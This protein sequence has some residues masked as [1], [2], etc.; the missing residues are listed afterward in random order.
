MSKKKLL[1]QGQKTGNLI[2]SRLFLGISLVI[3]G[4]ILVFGRSGGRSLENS[5]AN[6]PVKVEGFNEVK[7]QED[8]EP[9]RV[10]IP[11]AGIDLPV[12]RAEIIRGYWEVFP[13]TAAWGAGS[14]Y[15]GEAGNQ[16]VF[17]HAREGLFLPLKDVRIDDKVYI[18]T[19]DG[20]FDYKITEIKDV[21][22][23]QIEV[24]APTDDETLTLYTC[25]G[26]QDSKRLIVTAKRV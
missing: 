9:L 22:P 14:G 21:Y 26:Y 11:T 24:V 25:T 16:V 19:K 10:I 4:A 2:T 15:P 5:F 17:A 12:K 20:W 18:F 23:N 1:R 8:K 13:D 3:L 6:E 7:R